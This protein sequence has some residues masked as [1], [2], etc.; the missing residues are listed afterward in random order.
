MYTSTGKFQATKLQ[1]NK[2]IMQATK[3]TWELGMEE[4]DRKCEIRR[5]GVTKQTGQYTKPMDEESTRKK[6]GKYEG[7]VFL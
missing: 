7:A 2:W 5:Q 4:K 3:K 6:P 1:G